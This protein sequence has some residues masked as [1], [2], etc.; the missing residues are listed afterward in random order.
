MEYTELI[1]NAKPLREDAMPLGISGMTSV[2][3][4]EIRERMM[5]VF[6]QDDRLRRSLPLKDDEQERF[7]R[8]IAPALE[9]EA[10]PEPEPEPK[11]EPKPEPE[12]APKAE[13]KPK[14][15]SRRAPAKKKTE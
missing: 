6:Y 10:E 12:P 3:Y 15:T 4:T 11:P 7:E 9:L 13:A 1:D 5:L 14:A 8:A 2:G